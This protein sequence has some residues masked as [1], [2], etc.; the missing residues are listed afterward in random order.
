MNINDIK[1]KM[2]HYWKT[3]NKTIALCR[4]ILS[5]IAILFIIIIILWGYTGQWFQ[6]PIVAIESGSMEH[7]PPIHQTN[8]PFGRIGTIDAGDLVLIKKVNSGD[9]I[10]THGGPFGG[11]QAE[12]G[13]RS[14]GSYGDVIVFYP[15]GNTGITPVIHRAMCWVDVNIINDLPTYTIR[16]YGIYNEAFIP[17]IPEL[18]L[19][20]EVQPEW[21][22]SGFLTKGDNNRLFDNL[23]TQGIYESTQP[24]KPEWIKGKAR[25]EIP[26]FGTINL[27][28]SDLVKGTNNI[29]NVPTDSLICF[30]ILIISI[31][32]T[33]LVIDIKD[34]LRKNI[35]D[36][37]AN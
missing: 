29:K 34:Y 25:L 9:D 36:K 18:G 23:P 32:V 17:P 21:T 28:F 22:H 6:A 31:V 19:E 30:G 35:K 15:D 8:P 10:I 7:T 16:E 1:E 11:A 26:W 13:W 14:Y 3:D 2:L 12:N 27:F 33:L 24:I 5:M 20:T 37:D 4:D